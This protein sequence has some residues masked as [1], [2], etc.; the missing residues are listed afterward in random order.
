M[1]DNYSAKIIKVKTVPHPDPETLRLQIAIWNGLEF[2]VGIDVLD[3]LMILFPA[4]CQIDETY[5]KQNDLVKVKHED[6]TTSGGMLEENRRVKALKLRGVRSEGL[7]MP[8]SSLDYLGD[9]SKLSDGDVLKDFNGVELAKR[10]YPKHYKAP[11]GPSKKKPVV[12]EVFF[13]HAD[14]ANFRHNVRHVKNGSLLSYTL[15][16]HGT[17]GR[18]GLLPVTKTVP[19]PKLKWWQTL[20]KKRPEATTETSYELLTGS[21]R[22]VI[23]EESNGGYYGTNDFRIQAS[24]RLRHCVGKNETWYYE[25]VG[26]LPGTE[27]PIMNPVSSKVLKDKAFTKQY[28]DRITYKYGCPVGT[29]DVYVY[30]ITVTNEDGLVYDLPW[31]VVK[32]KC[33]GAD[34]KH[35]PDVT[36][37]EI[38]EHFLIESEVV[39]DDGTVKKFK[40]VDSFVYDEL[41][42]FVDQFVDGPDLIDSSHP[43]EGVVVRVDGPSGKTD[44]MKCKSLNFLI[45]EQAVELPDIEEEESLVEN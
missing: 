31:N 13:E 7:L 30:R 37:P 21:R 8:L 25:I 40:T 36:S 38:F 14:T 11:S 16:M 32:A 24:E 18:T 4:G 9:T 6:G 23:T 29:F 34:V 5:C 2:L 22:T 3:G 20:L 41:L 35:V 28:G 27:S 15:K 33:W 1:S 12:C 42:K 19:A 39:L 43:R 45:L 17:S 44:F 26:W 10:F